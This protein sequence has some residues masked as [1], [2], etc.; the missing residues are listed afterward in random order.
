MLF[1]LSILESV[2]PGPRHLL[3][4]RLSLPRWD[5]SG[6]DSCLLQSGCLSEQLEKDNQCK[7]ETNVKVC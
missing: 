6:S 5:S 1:F 2:M 4:C 3:P 7:T